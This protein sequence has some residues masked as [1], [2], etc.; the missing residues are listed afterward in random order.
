MRYKCATQAKFNSNSSAGYQNISSLNYSL[1]KA[2]MINRF[3]ALAVF[4]LVIA[5]SCS[6]HPFYQTNKIYRK[7]AKQY[8][9]EIG[10][11]PAL[12]NSNL[13]IAPY[14]VGTTNFNIRKPNFVI[15]H[16]TAQNSCDQTLRAFTLA[17][18]QVSAHYV[19]CKDGTVHHLLNDYL[20]AWHAGIAKWGSVTDINS[21]SVG[22]EIDNNGFETFTEPT[23][24]QFAAVARYFKKEIF[25]SCSK[26]YRPFG[27]CPNP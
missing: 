16:H 1:K 10:S 13:K 9:K 7:Q 4:I 22:I 27:Y 3:M 6:R 24:E 8:A 21:S 17:S 18:S 14:W 15:I 5:Y 25:H 19:I 23:D 26:L 20:R 2:S 11:T 12:L